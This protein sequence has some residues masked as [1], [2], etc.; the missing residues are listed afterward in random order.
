MKRP[1]FILLCTAVLLL[2]GCDIIKQQLSAPYIRNLS[3]AP[4]DVVIVPGVPFDSGKVS[5]IYKARLLWVKALFDKGIAKNIIFSGAATHNAYVEG[6]TMK[7]MADALGIPTENTFVESSALHS[8][9]NVAYSVALAHQLGFK[10]IAV[11]T[12]PFQSY[13]LKHHLADDNFKVALLPFSLDSMPV[14]FKRTLPQVDVTSARVENFIP[15]EKREL[16]L[17]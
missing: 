12:D 7:I 9:E 5:V 11:A 8:V 13:Y 4:F 2:T 15:L 14:Y 10:K 1:N 17:K 6:Q 3:S 16:A